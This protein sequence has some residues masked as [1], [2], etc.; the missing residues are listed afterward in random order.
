MRV[1]PAPRMTVFPESDGLTVRIPPYFKGGPICVDSG[2]L[3]P[4][5]T[6]EV[7]QDVI[8]SEIEPSNA[9]RSTGEG[10]PSDESMS[11]KVRRA[12]GWG[13]SRSIGVRQRGIRPRQRLTYG[14]WTMPRAT[15]RCC[16]KLSDAVVAAG[17]HGDG[18]RTG[19]SVRFGMPALRDLHS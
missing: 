5:V 12:S 9:R 11:R 7:A 10:V 4:A 1:S 3:E 19:R 13:G 15:S 6:V 14:E 2:P 17:T 8:R 18:R 16:V